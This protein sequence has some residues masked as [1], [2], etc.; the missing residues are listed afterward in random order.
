[1]QRPLIYKLIF[2]YPIQA[3]LFRY[4]AIILF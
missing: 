2:I 4:H 3:F 1:M